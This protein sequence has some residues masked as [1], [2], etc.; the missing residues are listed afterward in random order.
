MSWFGD[1]WSTYAW[2]RSERQLGR[3]DYPRTVLER[4]FRHYIRKDNPRGCDC[5]QAIGMI[6]RSI[7]MPLFGGGNRWYGADCLVAEARFVVLEEYL[8]PGARGTG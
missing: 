7:G 3:L 8:R 5:T 2:G 6:A 1:K 4:S